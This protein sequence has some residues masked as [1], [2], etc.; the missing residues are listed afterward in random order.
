MLSC[1]KIMRFYAKSTIWTKLLLWIFIILI[2]VGFTNQ[3]KP[4]R[5]GFIQKEKLY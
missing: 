5:E 1:K 4:I 2:I 3:F